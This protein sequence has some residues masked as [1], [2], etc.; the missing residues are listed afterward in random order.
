MS[1]IGMLGRLYCKK[2]HKKYCE[3]VAINSAPPRYYALNH[4]SR[5][6][7][8]VEQA[9]VYKDKD[10]NYHIETRTIC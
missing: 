1:L 10:Q 6:G 5:C 4:C 7:W 9:D 8:A 2:F 3:W